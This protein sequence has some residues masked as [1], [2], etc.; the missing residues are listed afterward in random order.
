[1]R[2]VKALIIWTA[3]A[4]VSAFSLMSCNAV[5][6]TDA[7]IIVPRTG[8]TIRPFIFLGIA[9][10]AVLVVVVCIV[11]S[12]K[13]KKTADDDSLKDHS[14]TEE[15]VETLPEDSDSEVNDS[16]EHDSDHKN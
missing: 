16:D 11:M 5:S 15:A 2:K 13:K 8:D 3:A 7:D 10:L 9:L 12:A 1:M 4:A 14:D 6:Y